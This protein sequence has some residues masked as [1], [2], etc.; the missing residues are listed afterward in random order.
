MG[1]LGMVLTPGPN[2]VYLIS[3]S[4]CQGRKA[5]LISLGGVAMGF[6]GYML[7]VAFGI[8][9]LVFSNPHAYDA[10]RYTG[11][12]YLS[13]LGIKSIKNR[14]GSPFELKPM[15]REPAGKLFSKGLLTNLLNPKIALMYMAL[16]PQ[17]VDPSRGT[18]LTQV[19]AFGSAQIGIS[20]T[21][22]A[23]IALMAGSISTL[24]LSRPTWLRTQRWFMGGVL[25]CLALHL[26]WH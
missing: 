3:T 25:I 24:L 10:I 23:I 6:V 2:M 12:A 14:T 9:A 7:L 26:L 8:S 5:G 17:F 21:V 22:N 4:V 19:L 11:A 13:Y 20:I 1:A 15:S 18:L 16:L